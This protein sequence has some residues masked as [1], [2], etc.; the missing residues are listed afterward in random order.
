MKNLKWF[1]F[2][3]IWLVI[4][5]DDSES[6]YG[7]GYQDRCINIL[8]SPLTINE[9]VNKPGAKVFRR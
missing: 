9:T 5:A 1:V 2:V 4:I 3:H 8:K 6:E 7:Y